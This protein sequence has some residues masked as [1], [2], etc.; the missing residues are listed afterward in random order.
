MWLECFLL[1]KQRRNNS[2]ER[3][4][5]ASIGEEFRKQAQETACDLIDFSI[6]SHVLRLRAN[7]SGKKPA[8]M[9]CQINRSEGRKL[10]AMSNDVLMKRPLFH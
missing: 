9:L 5:L 6:R 7:Q 4:K 1:C 8:E 3:A 10:F 2:S